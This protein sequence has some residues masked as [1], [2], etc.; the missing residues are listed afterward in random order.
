MDSVQL[1]DAFENILHI[2]MPNHEFEVL[3]KK[4]NLKRDGT[5]TW[6]EFISYLLVEFQKK[7]AALQWKIL[8]LP[9]TGI[10]QLLKSRHRTSIY[11]I[12]FCPEVLSLG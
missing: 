11:K 8:K 3:F 1:F 5:V 12:V 10:P 7:D 6:D 4:M 2:Q 9:I